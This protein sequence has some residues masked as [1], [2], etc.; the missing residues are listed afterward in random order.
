MQESGFFNA[1]EMMDKTR[2]PGLIALFIVC[3]PAFADIG[4][5]EFLRNQERQK[6]LQERI[7][8]QPDVRL[9]SGT[10]RFAVGGSGHIA[11]IVNPSAADKYGYWVNDARPLPE[12]AE[13]YLAGAA[14]YPGSWWTDWQ[15]WVCAQTGGKEQ[16]AARSQPIE[17]A[18][19]SYIK[20]R[21]EAPD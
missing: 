19:G 15:V 18:P 11:G 2:R 13:D 20:L 6:Q 21:L 8:P 7:P 3:S 1:L 16:V 14:Q 17:D 10:V 12:A 5:E 4:T 9:P